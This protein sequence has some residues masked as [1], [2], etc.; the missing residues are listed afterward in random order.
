M[1]ETAGGHVEGCAL[2]NLSPVRSVTVR[3]D[4]GN[5]FSIPVNERGLWAL[6]PAAGRHRIVLA[7]TSLS[8]RSMSV[9][10]DVGDGLLAK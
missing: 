4:G 7:A 9:Q 5:P 2:D 6:P 1:A 8:G 10:M 3:V